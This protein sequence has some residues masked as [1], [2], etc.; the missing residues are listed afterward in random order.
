M[1][2][3]TG[4]N[5]WTKIEKLFFEQGQN[6]Y[7][8]EPVSQREH[9]LQAAKCAMD[10]TRCQEGIF[11]REEVVLAALL[12]DIGHMLGLRDPSGTKRMGDCG[13]FDHEGI[14]GDFVETLGMSPRVAKLVR[15]HVNAKRYLT[16]TNASYFEKL[17]QA[18]R[19]TLGFQG[20]PFTQDECKAFE[21]D[22]D[23]DIILLMRQWDEA[24]KIPNLSVPG[25]ECYRDMI[26]RN[27]ES[28]R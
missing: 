22:E 6:D 1:S 5:A 3:I 17:S 16:G 21:G 2:G 28:S 15:Q 12:H 24:A 19:T 23:F 25:L 8:G 27:V 14:G 13:V 20:G 11:A 26:C 7:I 4:E 10:A 9:S 18:S